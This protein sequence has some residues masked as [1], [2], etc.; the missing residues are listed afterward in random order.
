MNEGMNI[1]ELK[2]AMQESMDA[3]MHYL[4]PPRLGQ[5]ILDRVPGCTLTMGVDGNV[6]FTEP[7]GS[8]TSLS[9]TYKDAETKRRIMQ[10]HGVT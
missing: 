5:L 7:G 3:P 6:V 2:Q 8:K 9:T 10:E 4:L 1:Q